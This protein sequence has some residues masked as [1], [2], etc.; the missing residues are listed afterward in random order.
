MSNS[1]SICL[2]SGKSID[3]SDFEYIACK[4]GDKDVKI[5]NFENFYLYNRLL[6]FVGKGTIVALSSTDI[7]F[8]RFDGN[9]NVK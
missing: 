3:I 9:F 1:V 8:I 6:T 2:K 5:T 4:S 7:E